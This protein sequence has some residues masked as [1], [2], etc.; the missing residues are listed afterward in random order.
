MTILQVASY[1]LNTQTAVTDLKLQKLLYYVKVWGLVSGNHVISEDFIKW[2]HGPVNR[3]I[4][5]T[6]KK[7]GYSP[8]PKS[9]FKKPSNIE[10]KQFVD[11]ILECYSPYDAIT[12]SAMTH[13]DAP[14]K[15]T[16]LN[17]IISD[18]SITKYYSSLPFTKNFPF[19]P[20][21]PFY[22]VQSNLHYAFIFDMDEKTVE[23]TLAYPSYT[24][25]KKQQEKA[26]HDV[27]KW[28]SRLV[29]SSK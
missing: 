3:K 8:I 15:E 9:D 7:Y 28:L 6:C 23:K 25:Y 13:Q 14:W 26:E 24:A 10:H 17:S 16:P 4:Y 12:L 1:I 11:F 2:A 27:N 21:K 19:D 18:Q 20:E 22:P 29:N 5:D